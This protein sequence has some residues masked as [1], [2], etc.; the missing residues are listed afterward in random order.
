MTKLIRVLSIDGGGIRGIIPGQVLVYLEKQLQIKSGNANA[1][2]ADYFDFVAGTSTGGILTCALLTPDAPGSTK[3]KYTATEV[4][5][6]YKD[7]GTDVFNLPFWHK[8]KS[9]DGVVDE[10]YPSDGIESALKD[11][12]ADGQFKDLIKPCLITSYDIERRRAHFFTSIDAKVDADSNFKVVDVARSTSAA[13]TYFQAASVKAMS[14]KEFALIDG[15]V[16]ANNPTLCAYAE[17]RQH[18]KNFADSQKNATA[19]EMMILSIGTGVSEKT[20]MYEDAKDWGMAQ[21]VKP[22]ID[23]MMSGVSE[24]TDFVLQ[25][26]FD[27]VDK[28][29]QYV[30][31]NI[32]IPQGTSTEMDNAT[33]ENIKALMLLGE[34][35]VDD[36]KRTLDKVVDMLLESV[37]VMA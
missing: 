27:S 24:T 12:F 7:R 14:G 1:R 31:V 26:M 5:G 10:K 28:P 17:I 19:K 36:Q 6:F 30:R 4:L 35:L 9:A 11:Y 23:I 2:I 20:Y 29:E 16:F 32:E 34:K 21:W 8:I 15:G 37:A 13:P 33:P 18:V 25:Q 3:A 22:I